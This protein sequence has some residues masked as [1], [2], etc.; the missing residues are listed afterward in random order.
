MAGVAILEAALRAVGA[1]RA[2]VSQ[3]ALREGM[4]IEELSAQQQWQLGLSARERSAAEL[5][6][7]FMVGLPHARHVTALSQDLLSRLTRRGEVLPDDAHDL[8]SAAAFLHEIGQSVS[9]SSHHKHS[10]YLIR[11]GGLRGFDPRQLDL[12]AQIAR[13]HRKSTP[14]A[15]HPEFQALGSPERSSVSKLAAI[16][17]VADGLDRTH[18]GQSRIVDLHRG[19]GSWTLTVSGAAPL[20][21]IGAQEKSDLWQQVY[22]ELTVQ[23][24][25]GTSQAALPRP[26]RRVG[27]DA[28]K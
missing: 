7:R 5:A 12:I 23:A 1:A 15:S 13:Y 17:R 20:D 21:L 28:P 4:L 14:K 26:E 16:L 2:T 10:A 25:S 19:G 24:V 3:G 9:L 6:E 22:G 11:H 27:L 8:L 18:A